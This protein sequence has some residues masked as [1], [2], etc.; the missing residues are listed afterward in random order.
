LRF[1]TENI[2]ILIQLVLGVTVI[3]LLFREKRARK[4]ESMR[5][6]FDEEM[7]KQRDSLDQ[8]VN[9]RTRELRRAMQKA[10]DANRAKTEFLANMNHEIRTPLNVITGF[11]Y[12]LKEESKGNEKAVEAVENIEKACENLTN[13]IS[14]ILDI[15][16]IEV[17]KMKLDPDFINIYD[18][19]DEIRKAYMPRS[20]EKNIVFSVNIDDKM[21]KVV[22]ID[23]TRLRQ[24]I[25]NLVGNS[26]KFTETGEIRVWSYAS[27]SD[28]KG[29]VD[30][31]ITVKDTGIGIPPEQKDKMFEPFV[32]QDGQSTRKY[33]GTG[34]GLALCRKFVEMMGGTISVESEPGRGSVFFV[35]IKG[36]EVS[37]DLVRSELKRLSESSK[38]VRFNG[39]KVLIAE[40][41]IM[42]RE[43]LKNFLSA[44]NLN[45]FEVSNGRDAVSVAKNIKP[46]IILMDIL[47]PD[48]DGLSASKVIRNNAE[49]KHIPII[50]VTALAGRD[51]VPEIL[52]VCSALIEKPVRKEVLFEKICEFLKVEGNENK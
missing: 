13:I 50:A 4:A 20:A 3:I 29:C 25:H 7:K 31:T 26:F 16:K 23:G 14:D 30:I 35:S 36:V 1:A 52:R 21:P 27:V 32:Q 41:N 46:D 8:I 28:I 34:L 43:V 45:I 42:N 5:K 33:G 22:K 47:M 2:N 10:E 48:L 44:S 49:L 40:D 38:S 17:G 6:M 12:L 11:S 39:E 51:Q 15:S 24:I 9:E 19:F 18:L 37:K